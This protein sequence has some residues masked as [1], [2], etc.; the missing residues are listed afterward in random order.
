MTISG[1][2]ITGLEGLWIGEASKVYKN[3][4]DSARAGVNRYLTIVAQIASIFNAI[5]I[6][7]KVSQAASLTMPKN[8]SLG[9]Q[10]I[11]YLTPIITNLLCSKL[12]LQKNP[13]IKR[14]LIFINTHIG[15]VCQVA[16][17]VSSVAL[18]ILGQPILGTVSLAFVI[19]GFVQRRNWLP[20]KVSQGIDAIGFIGINIARIS[21]GDPFYKFI[22]VCEIGNFAYL[23][24]VQLKKQH[25]SPARIEP[26]NILITNIP[27]L[28]DI[29]IDSRNLAAESLISEPPPV[30]L[31]DLEN[32]FQKYDL[33]NP[34]YFG[35]VKKFVTKD[36]HWI[37]NYSDRNKDEQL[38]E[39]I[40]QGIK[41]LF[42]II[43]NST[44]ASD[45]I[46]DN[47][48][49][50][51]R[52]KHI[53][54]QLPNLSE[55]DQLINIIKL[56]LATYY[57]HPGFVEKVRAVYY[58]V[59]NAMEEDSIESRLTQILSDARRQLF[60][61]FLYDFFYVK[62]N[63]AKFFLDPQDNHFYNEFVN[64]LGDDFNLAEVEDAKHDALASLDIFSKKILNLMYKPFTRQF[65][66]KYNKKFIIRALAEGIKNRQIPNAQIESWFI[67]EY[68]LALR[69]YLRPQEDNESERNYNE[70]IRKEVEQKVLK[71]AYN[72]MTGQI[73]I[74]YLCFFLLRMG[75]FKVT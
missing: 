14:A 32:I 49:I 74:K 17:A 69:P 29:S 53:T 8:I 61:T 67:D 75:I 66:K 33:K 48:S 16:V 18:I 5:Y 72:Y 23:K 46:S 57:C 22:A 4:D 63:L 6:A 28:K 2:A 45:A 51:A 21:L 36:E 3:I 40:N 34:I 7:Q 47:C 10:S 50:L 55:E 62:P 54:H 20:L 41:N 58:T 13:E 12:S 24:I 26:P 60:H 73:K 42:E 1:I 68:G 52:V 59:C 37:E 56:S 43:A 15:T 38:V 9:I 65:I 30:D 19:A 44:T 70:S 27:K 39:Y 31:K 25:S 64:L 35:F 71:N 11:L